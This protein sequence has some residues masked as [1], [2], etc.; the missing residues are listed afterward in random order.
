MNWKFK[1]II[2]FILL[3]AVIAVGVI[4]LMI[5]TGSM[6]HQ[7]QV[8]EQKPFTRT[9]GHIVPVPKKMP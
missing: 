4:G 7:K 8:E 1:D 5:E 2:L 3:Q 6:D 9:F